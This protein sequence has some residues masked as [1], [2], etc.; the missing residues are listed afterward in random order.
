[1]QKPIPTEDIVAW[2]TQILKALQ[3]MHTEMRVAHCNLK[4]SNIL[5]DEYGYAKVR[6][7]AIPG[8]QQAERL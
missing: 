8:A 2:M 6:D 7:V 1:M 4:L 5:V 3:Y